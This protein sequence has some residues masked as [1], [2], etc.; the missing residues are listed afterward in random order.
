MCGFFITGG[1]QHVRATKEG[2]EQ[3]RIFE[4]QGLGDKKFFE[5]DEIGMADLAFGSLAWWLPV[6]SEIAGVK[7]I[8]AES[9]P[10]LHAWIQRFKEFPTIKETLPDRSALLT[11]FKDRRATFLAL[12]KS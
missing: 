7:V 12:A 10:R 1:E 2:Q 3:L 4:E 6:M 8:E 11:Y 5:G 9:F